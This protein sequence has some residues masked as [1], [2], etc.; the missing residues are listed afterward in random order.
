MFY[1]RSKKI[2]SKITVGIL[3]VCFGVGMIGI[4]GVV[5][6]QSDTGTSD[7]EGEI[8]R[9]REEIIQRIRELIVVLRGRI[10]EARKKQ[11]RNEQ[12]S[13]SDSEVRARLTADLLDTSFIQEWYQVGPL[14]DDR[15]FRIIYKADLSVSAENGDV[16]LKPSEVR[17][18]LYQTER[19]FRDPSITLSSTRYGGETEFFVMSDEREHHPGEGEDIIIRDGNEKRITLVLRAEPYPPGPVSLEEC[20]T[21]GM[22]SLSRECNATEAI[23]V[24]PHAHFA[25][26]VNERGAIELARKDVRLDDNEQSIN[27]EVVLDVTA[28]DDRRVVRTDTLSGQLKHDGASV[29]TFTGFERSGDVT[30][31]QRI[32]SLR[33]SRPKL[34]RGAT[35]QITL[36]GVTPHFEDGTYTGRLNLYDIDYP[37]GTFT[38]QMSPVDRR[39]QKYR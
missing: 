23:F 22:T 32:S 29:E 28:H 15:K 12:S 1:M 19:A 25:Y 16:V 24:M 35:E 17:G 14:P 34:D 3:C 4:A 11:E 18:T 36:R 7:S 30:S 39:M 20:D 10:E 37:L 27:G 8:T 6:A 38:F 26:V 13:V 33:T 5:E 2:R 9:T 21:L 31:I